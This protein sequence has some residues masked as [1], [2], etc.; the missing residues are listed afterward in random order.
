ME[1]DLH[2]TDGGAPVEKPETRRAVTLAQCAIIARRS[3]YWGLHVR[4]SQPD[5]PKPLGRLVRKFRAGNR[6]LLYSEDEFR[7]WLR[8]YMRG[9][10]TTGRGHTWEPLHGKRKR[11][12]KDKD[13][14]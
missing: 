10:E 1:S 13:N 2:M 11:T 14:G 5:F 6:P 3:L 8:N 7:A 9:L 12:R 4:H